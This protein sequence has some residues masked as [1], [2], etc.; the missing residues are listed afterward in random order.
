MGE[1]KKS[2]KRDKEVGMVEV[3]VRKS[4]M[5]LTEIILWSTRTVEDRNLEIIMD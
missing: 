2:I 5:L 1:G 3:N 4:S